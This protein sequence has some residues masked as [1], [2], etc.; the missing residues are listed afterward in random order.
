MFIII[1]FLGHK[2]C[3]Y[4]NNFLKDLFLIIGLKIINEIKYL[5]K[6][7]LFWLNFNLDINSKELILWNIALKVLCVTINRIYL[8]YQFTLWIMG[9]VNPWYPVFWNISLY[10]FKNGDA[11]LFTPLALLILSCF[12]FHLVICLLN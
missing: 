11:L 12:V 2:L 3:H 4:F 9:I 1:S 8:V 5:C 6:N 10:L 7:F